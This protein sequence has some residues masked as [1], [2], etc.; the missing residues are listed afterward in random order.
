MQRARIA[1]RYS[2]PDLNIEEIRASLLARNTSKIFCTRM[3]QNLDARC[4]LQDNKYPLHEK[5]RTSLKSCPEG[6]HVFLLPATF[7]PISG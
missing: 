6:T 2:L 7:I 5:S 1:R 4:P 3:R